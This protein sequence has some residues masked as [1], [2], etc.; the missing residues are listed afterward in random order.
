MSD[1]FCPG[2]YFYTL[3]VWYGMDKVGL[4]L[5]RLATAKQLEQAIVF[6][7]IYKLLDLDKDMKVDLLFL[8][9]GRRPN[10]FEKQKT[11]SQ[12]F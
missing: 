4:L 10:F 7:Y 11:T 3:I 8:A 6:I 12:S 1:M 2:G 5:F 9:N